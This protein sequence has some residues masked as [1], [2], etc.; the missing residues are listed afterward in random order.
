M[1]LEIMLLVNTELNSV[2]KVKNS[3]TDEEIDV[4]TIAEDDK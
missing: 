4:G 1:V 2:V 3:E